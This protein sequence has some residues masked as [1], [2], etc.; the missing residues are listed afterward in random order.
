MAKQIYIF[1]ID[2]TIAESG[3]PIDLEMLNLLVVK[4]TCWT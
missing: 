4:S 1:D 3:K 2:G